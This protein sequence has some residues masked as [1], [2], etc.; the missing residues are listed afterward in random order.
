MKSRFDFAIQI[1]NQ[2]ASWK[3]GIRSEVLSECGLHEY[4]TKNVS[5]RED[6]FEKNLY[7]D[8][9][10]K[11]NCFDSGHASGGSESESANG[12]RSTGSDLV[13]TAS[14][15]LKELDRVQI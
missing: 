15:F 14:A 5:A 12:S 1:L 11:Y 9:D 4:V 6:G 8:C 3:A 10:G 13:A 7:F 2:C